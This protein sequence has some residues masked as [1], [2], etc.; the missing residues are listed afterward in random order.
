MN[1]TDKKLKD[2][3]KQ[4]VRTSTW[5][6]IF[7]LDE[8]LTTEENM[9]KDAANSYAQDKLMPRVLDNNRNETFDKN[10]FREMGDLGLL[11]ATITGYDCPGVSYVA[12]GL[13]AREIERVDSSYRSC[14]S[15]QS[16]L[17]MHPIYTFGS[18]SQKQRFLPK[19]A[20]GE[21]IGAFGLTEPNHGS[22]PGNMETKSVSTKEVIY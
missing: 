3:N 22:D 6:D 16:S 18:E 10:I 2:I 14:M 11:G 13:I 20:S 19:L 7:L 17:V 21:L 8:Q 4:D 5:S 1:F 15:V 12:Y 9:I